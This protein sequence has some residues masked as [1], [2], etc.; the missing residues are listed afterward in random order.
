MPT[1]TKIFDPANDAI[2]ADIKNELR[3]QGHY[4][5]GALEASLRS[6]EISEN[7]NII[8]T[9][10][11]LSYLED[12]EEGIP[13]NE[14]GTDPAS[15]AE[16]T[17]YVQL[18]MGYTGKYAIKVALAILRK[19]QLEGNPTNASYEYSKTGDRLDAVKET[20]RQNQGKYIEM[21][22]TP[23]V[24]SLDTIFNQTKSGTI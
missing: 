15:I 16:M 12:L 23:A 8:L 24:N 6:R 1:N 3:L 14:I 18:R 17:K 4:L 11:S 20:F 2:I 13:G 9:A 22:D 21:I 7:G 10:Q 5:T 19:Q